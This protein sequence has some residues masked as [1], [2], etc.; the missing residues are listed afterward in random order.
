M[1]NKIRVL[2][3]IPGMASGGVAK[4]AQE[5]YENI[6]KNEFEMEIATLDTLGLFSNILSE[7]GCKI[8]TF[9]PL[10]EVGLFKYIKELNTIIKSGKYDIIHSHMGLLSFL[11]FFISIRNKI[12]C[13]FLH[14]HT[15]LFYNDTSNGIKR[16]FINSIKKLCVLLATD[17][18]ACTNEAGNY[19]FGNKIT[20]TN[21]YTLLLNGINIDKFA[22]NSEKRIE[23]RDRYIKNNEFIIGN[24]GRFSEQKNHKFILK[25][26]NEIIK[27][28]NNCKLWL[29]G[30]G[31]D[32]SKIKDL[33][34]DLGLENKVEFLGVKSNIEDYMQA[35]DVFLM[36]SLFEGLG[37]VAIEAQ[38]TGLSCVV[39][40]MVPKEVEV[41]ENVIF[42]SLDDPIIKWSECIYKLKNSIRKNCTNEIIQSGYDTR[43][44]SELMYRKYKESLK[45]WQ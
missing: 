6:N 12:K 38:A 40:T 43:S 4:L 34:N 19:F 13:R 39:S 32:E 37:I 27:I 18:F 29:I 42:L 41:S 21:K 20:K 10:R 30:E 11:V 35:M 16:V 2:H 36:P 17:Y 8:I 14:A 28:D 26:F 5:W 15:N 23:M 3:V 1:K 9:K 33:V 22:F 44:C 31:E 24:V 7:K 45:N 25:V